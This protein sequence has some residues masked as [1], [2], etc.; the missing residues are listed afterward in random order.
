MLISILTYSQDY[1]PKSI[2]PFADNTEINSDSLANFINKK[3]ISDSTL[4]KEKLIKQNRKESWL[5]I[6][7]VNL[8][9]GGSLLGLVTSDT[10]IEEATSPSG[11]IGL[12]FTTD[13]I[14]C[15]LYFS[16]NSRKSIE[17]E[18]ISQFGNS[19]M[20]PILDGQSFTFSTLGRLS[21]KF[22][23]SANFQIADNLWKIDE[24]TEIDVSPLIA[25]LGIYYRPFDFE[26]END[27]KI[28]L[29]FNLHFT[30]RNLLG[31]FGNNPQFID[32][33]N[34]SQKNYNG[35][36]F[37]VNTYLNSVHLYIQYS[38]NKKKDIYI[39]GFSGSQVLFGINVTGNL[40]NL[41]KKQ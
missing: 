33:F 26:M 18:N 16:Y 14:S 30:H 35:I 1:I 13:R 38:N 11:S 25:K 3:N 41:K 4:A 37:S 32:G 12:N 10:K 29:T 5:K 31:D 2:R 28:D 22:G 27:N 20:N 21:E 23:F 40:I 8:Y 36:D 15:N 24:D 7:S 34:V 39:P 9:G 19:L 6:R 17:M